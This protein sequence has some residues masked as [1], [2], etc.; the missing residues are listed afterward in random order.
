MKKE[1]DGLVED[2]E[3]IMAAMKDYISELK[4]IALMGAIDKETD[5]RIMELKLTLKPLC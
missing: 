1:L 2:R 4:D 5:S 3:L